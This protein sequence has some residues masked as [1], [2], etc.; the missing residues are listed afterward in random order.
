MK[1][2]GAA[3]AFAGAFVGVTVTVPVQD[4]GGKDKPSEVAGLCGRI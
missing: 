3:W 2:V 1:V 4:I